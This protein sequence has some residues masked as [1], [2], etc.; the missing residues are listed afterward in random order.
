MKS[1]WLVQPQ[2]ER[3]EVDL[4]VSSTR[5]SDDIKSTMDGRLGVHGQNSPREAFSERQV[6]PRLV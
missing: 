2:R 4:V 5:L 6:S 3:A 1:D